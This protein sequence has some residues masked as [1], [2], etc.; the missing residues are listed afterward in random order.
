MAHGDFLF[1]DL[2]PQLL[3][4]L[5]ARR[6]S[7]RNGIIPKDFAD[8]TENP[9]DGYHHRGQVQTVPAIQKELS[10]FITLCG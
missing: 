8:V 4:R 6:S 9:C 5:L 3:I 1:S 2:E 7:G 10:V